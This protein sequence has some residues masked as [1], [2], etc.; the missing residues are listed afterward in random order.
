MKLIDL[1][2]KLI[3]EFS[4]SGIEFPEFEAK[5]LIKH[6]FSFDET[7]FI[8][9]R[10]FEISEEKL[11]DINT[12]AIRRK[13]GEP[14]QYIIGRW[15]F[16]NNTF[17]VGDGVLIPRP[18]TEILCEYV[19]ESIK[20]FDNPVVYDLC[21]GSGCI[22]ISVK[23]EVP[24]SDV[25]CIEKSDNAFDYLSK[26]NRTIIDNK[27]HI[28]NADIFEPE[29]FETLP[30]ADIIVS[31]PPYIRTD[32]LSALQRE[33]H[34]EPSMALD[35]GEDGLIFYRFIIEKLKVYLKLSGVFAFECGEDQ[36]ADISAL[37]LANG[38]KPEIIKDFNN[39]DRI[40]IGR[41]NI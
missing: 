3:S 2:Y 41:R 25:Y 26:N 7:A 28:I 17:F 10:F 6:C 11:K 13:N 5:E 14:L 30:S 9:N 36:A 27:A 15:D 29:L 33:V 4:E 32:E 35:G 12:A 37:L 31:N 21:S 24:Q 1:Y 40:V 34:F 8:L 38:F 16:L 39:I 19:I 23:Y 22:G 20:N 18:E